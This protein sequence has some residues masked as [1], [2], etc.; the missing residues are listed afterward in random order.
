MPHPE[1]AQPS[2]SRPVSIGLTKPPQTRAPVEIRIFTAHRNRPL[3]RQTDMSNL[4]IVF[5]LLNILLDT[6]GHLAF[7]S[8]AAEQ[9]E[10]GI[11]RWKRML[12]SLP[13]WIGIACFGVEF[14]AWFALLSL[15]P[16]SLA[17]LIGSINI[18]VVVLAGWLLFQERLDRM[19]VTGMSLITIGVALAG[20]FA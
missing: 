17:M 2:E 13:L 14:G 7:K 10:I 6:V 18:V 4:A 3:H 8:A 15:I 20:G 1:G 12:S 5:W 16:L 9:H 11:Q 19:R